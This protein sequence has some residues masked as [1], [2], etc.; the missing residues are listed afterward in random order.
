MLHPSL[1]NQNMLKTQYAVRGEL[2]L[3]A[4]ELK[5]TGKEIM[6]TNGALAAP[7]SAH[8]YQPAHC[9]HKPRVTCCGASCERSGQP[10]QLRRTAYYLHAAGNRVPFTRTHP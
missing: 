1:L 2:Y 10:A 8:Q 3:K 4:E 9:M 6:F 7:L 5:K